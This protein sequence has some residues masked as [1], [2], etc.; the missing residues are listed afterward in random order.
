MF[1]P[2]YNIPKWSEVFKI[3]AQISSKDSFYIRGNDFKS[4]TQA[5]YTGAVTNPAW[6][7]FIQH[8]IFPDGSMALHE[9]HIFSPT[10]V[11]EAMFS[12][13]HS[14]ENGPAG[15]LERLQQGGKPHDSRIYRRAV[16]PP[17]QPL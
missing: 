15:R 9:T 12:A 16:L 1:Q 13:R 11:N 10:I 17:E 4:D 14:A 7:W 2:D 5:W 6:P 8:Y 3:D